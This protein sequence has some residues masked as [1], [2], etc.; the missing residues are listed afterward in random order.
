MSQ[1]QKDD[2]TSFDSDCDAFVYRM[3]RAKVITSH[4]VPVMRSALPL[5]IFKHKHENTKS[6]EEWYAEIIMLFIGV[7]MSTVLTDFNS[8]YFF[9]LIILF[10]SRVILY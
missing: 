10:T 6:I 1:M 7:L 3:A 5:L 2:K 8:F 4:G 9:L